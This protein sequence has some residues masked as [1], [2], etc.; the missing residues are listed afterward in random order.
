MV[1]LRSGK[2][3]P[4]RDPKRGQRQLKISENN[5]PRAARNVVSNTNT[6]VRDNSGRTA[7]VQ[8]IGLG[9]ANREVNDNETAVVRGNRTSRDI[10]C[11]DKGKVDQLN[12]PP[13]LLQTLNIDR[14]HI[15]LCQES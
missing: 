8:N 12:L 9:T 2:P 14:C 6:E 11:E 15:H 4:Q 7:V 3:I 1:A 10:T 13:F 5:S